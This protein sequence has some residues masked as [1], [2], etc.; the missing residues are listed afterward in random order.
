MTQ[1]IKSLFLSVKLIS[2]KY[3][4]APN[5]SNKDQNTMRGVNW[6]YI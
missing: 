6:G 1:G 5:G 2:L 3:L 4:M